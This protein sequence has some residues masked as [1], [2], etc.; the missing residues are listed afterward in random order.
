M[1][2][3]GG[4]KRSHGQELHVTPLSSEKCQGFQQHF[5]PFTGTKQCRHAERPC[6]GGTLPWDRHHT[7][8]A[9]GDVDDFFGS[10]TLANHQV[11]ETWRD[12]DQLRRVTQEPA[13]Q[14]VVDKVL[15]AMG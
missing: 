4:F 3:C 10:E 8:H 6:F 2:I 5:D 11:R 14:A 13:F 1:F 7:R 12:R 9:V 15:D